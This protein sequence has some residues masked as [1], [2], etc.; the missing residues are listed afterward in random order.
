MRRSDALAILPSEPEPEAPAA[1]PSSDEAAAPPVDVAA[2]EPLPPRPRTRGDCE[3]V[4]GGVRP[5]PYVGCRYH[6]VGAELHHGGAITIGNGPRRGPD[7]GVLASSASEAEVDAYVDG[8]V[9][10]LAAGPTCALDVIDDDPDGV[11]LDAVGDAIGVTRERIRQ[12]ESRAKRRLPK[13]VRRELH[14]SRADFRPGPAAQPDRD[15]A[16]PK[17]KWAAPRGRARV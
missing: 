3:V 7:L 17:P 10:V 11:V 16:A 4:W 1:P 9:E 13:E 8:L 12:I 14:L 2:D 6:I 15:H 5:C